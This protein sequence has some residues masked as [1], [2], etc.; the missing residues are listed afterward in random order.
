MPR[1][2][3]MSLKG[4]KMLDRAATGLDTRSVLWGVLRTGNSTPILTI[5]LRGKACNSNS[6]VSSQPASRIT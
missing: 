6:G 5:P 2:L 3:A 1:Q 4:A